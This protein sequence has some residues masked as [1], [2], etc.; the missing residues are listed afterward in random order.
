MNVPAND[1]P[2][3]GKR[4]V[5]TSAGL[6]IDQ[7]IKVSRKRKPI[8]KLDEARLLSQGGIPKLRRVAKERLKFKGK[9]HEYKDLSRL[10]NF[11]QLWLDDLY[12]RAKFADALCI[13]EKLGHTKRMQIM[14]REW[15]NEWKPESSCVE[16][17][18]ADQNISTGNIPSQGVASNGDRRGRRAEFPTSADRPTTPRTQ[19]RS[20]TPPRGILEADDDLYSATPGAV[21]QTNPLPQ[22]RDLMDH[23]LFV[24]E[25]ETGAQPEEDELDMLLAEDAAQDDHRQTGRAQD[26]ESRAVESP[27][28]NDFDDEM[29]V[30]AGMDDMW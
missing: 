23:S 21:R 14:R 17:T 18:D 19:Q 10:L 12:P 22:Q 26:H 28:A 13:I 4:G 7:E 6:G 11:Y 1:Q 8:A 20:R 3:P 29:E 15:I 27:V 30:M 2:R 5:E 25:D 9:G 24:T 16:G